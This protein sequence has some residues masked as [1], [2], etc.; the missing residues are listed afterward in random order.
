MAIDAQ[1]FFKPEDCAEMILNYQPTTRR[2]FEALYMNE[3]KLPPAKFK[4]E[5]RAGHDV[6]VGEYTFGPLEPK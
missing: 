5:P 3:P 1:K 4:I 2:A 6:V